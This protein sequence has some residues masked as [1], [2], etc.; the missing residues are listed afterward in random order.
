M[1]CFFLSRGFKKIEKTYFGNGCLKT[2]EISY[3]LHVRKRNDQKQLRWTTRKLKWIQAIN[4]HEKWLTLALIV[5]IHNCH[6]FWRRARW[7]KQLFCFF[8]N[9]YQSHLRKLISS[10]LKNIWD[11]DAKHDASNIWFKPST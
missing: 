6:L 8:K 4:K 10:K 7:C 3:E 9:P 11:W 5:Q 2:I 1:S